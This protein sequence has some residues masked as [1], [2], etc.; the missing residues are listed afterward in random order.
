MNII[1][2]DLADIDNVKNNVKHIDVFLNLAWSGLQRDSIDSDLVQAENVQISLKCAQLAI[3]LGCKV[4]MD[5]G[6]RA[7][8]GCPD[9]PMQEDMEC[10]PVTAYGM[11]K[12]EVY[13]KTM[14]LLKSHSL[15]YYHLRIFSVYGIG[16][17]PWSLIS[18]LTHELSDGK[19]VSLS[20]CLHY[21]N[22]MHIEDAVEAM[23]R[24]AEHGMASDNIEQI[25]VNIA[26]KDTRRLYEFVHEIHSCT[27]G[28][29]ELKF[30]AFQQGK[31]RMLSIIPDTKRLFSL[32]PDFKERHSFREGILS[33]LNSI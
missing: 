27:D 25:T 18:T 7:E 30:G 14:E 21:W 4:F 3:S 9:A 17:H 19:C 23:S 15:T 2:C 16:D 11:A 1:N 6:S 12:F 20:P 33:I 32:L 28:S 22:F 13:N 24:L 8:Y 31:E 26:S 29:G 5:A 10:I